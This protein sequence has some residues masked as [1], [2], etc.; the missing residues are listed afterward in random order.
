MLQTLAN[1][2]SIDKYWKKINSNSTVVEKIE[3]YNKLFLE[4]EFS[5]TL[6]AKDC[7]QNAL[8]LAKQLKNKKLE[9]KTLINFGYFAEDKSNSLEALSYYKASLNLGIQL[10]DKIIISD[11]FSN[12]GSVLYSQGNYAE[13]IKNYHACLKI[14]KAL[15][16]TFGIARSYN[17]IGVVYGNQGEYSKAINIYYASLKLFEAQKQLQGQAAAYANIGLLHQK[18]NNYSKALQ[19]SLMAL[20]IKLRS[21]D[22]PGIANS[23]NTIGLVYFGMAE[24][25]KD[26]LKKQIKL[27]SALSN[28]IRSQNI[29]EEIGD[30]GS[31]SF[32]LHNIAGVLFYNS[33]YEEALKN[34]FAS[35]KMKESIGDLEGISNALNN[36]GLV[37]FRQKKYNQAK[38]YLIKARDLSLKNKFRPTLENIFK[39]LTTIDSVMGNFKEALQNHKLY[40]CYQDSL[41][42]DEIRKKTLQSQMTYE[43][44]KKEAV[45]NFEYTKK[46]KKQKLLTEQKERKQNL[47]LL[48][49]SCGLLAVFIFA[50]LIFRT[51]KTAKKQKSII[52]S[53][54]QEV[55]TQKDLIEEKQNEIVASIHY[56]KKI[57]FALLPTNKYIHT[58][59]NKNKN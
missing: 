16:D 12:I 58:H 22:K 50:L 48:F 9:A 4:Y 47:I 17:N 56:A 2:D 54:K 53:Q 7:I 39:D 36:I 35:I 40:I 6:K 3:L 34:Y 38:I 23:Y 45:A 19:Y 44:E 14:K 46:A 26:P 57:Q 11:N 43:F 25:E 20:K 30:K 32:A 42:N 41:S 55:E 51:L 21:N 15:K 1:Q 49:V 13:A 18:Q 37:Y 31:L 28:Y 27:D 29:S 33:K 52:E 24:I 8:K 59:I 10:K 5:D